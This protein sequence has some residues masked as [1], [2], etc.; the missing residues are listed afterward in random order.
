MT[1]CSSPT[2]TDVAQLDSIWT[3]LES[4]FGYSR[5]RRYNLVT[6]ATPLDPEETAV[7]R[8]FN[9]TLEGSGTGN[10]IAGAGDV[11]T[12]VDVTIIIIIIVIIIIIF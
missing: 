10:A 3:M 4:D 12:S 6:E 5:P 11:A 8:T 9:V 2:V 7:A 1:S